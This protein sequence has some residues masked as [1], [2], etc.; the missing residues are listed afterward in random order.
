MHDE[1][2]R[3]NTTVSEALLGPGKQSQLHTPILDHFN[4]LKSLKIWELTESYSCEPNQP[5]TLTETMTINNGLGM[6]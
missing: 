3:F 5:N 2:K 6:F 4:R 1:L